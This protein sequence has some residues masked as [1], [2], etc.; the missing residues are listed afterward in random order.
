[1]LTS[2]S[3]RVTAPLRWISRARHQRWILLGARGFGKDGP[4]ETLCKVRRLVSTGQAA[5]ALARSGL[6]DRGWYASNNPDVAGTG[7]DPLWHFVRY[8]ASEKRRAS[9]LF[10]TRWYLETYPDVA[11]SG[12]NPLLH[13]LR[14]GAAEGRDPNPY[15]DSHWYLDTY[16]DVAAAGM[17]PLVH[18]Q[19]SGAAE[20]R[21]PSKGFDPDKYSRC[22]PGISGGKA[23]ALEH[24]LVTRA[25]VSEAA[26]RAP[27]SAPCLAYQ[28]LI[29]IIVPCLSVE[30]K[31]LR[32]A[33]ASVQA[34]TYPNWELCVC[35]DGSIAADTIDALLDLERTEAR[36]RTT[37][38]SANLGMSEA[39][40]KALAFAKGDFVA[41][42]QNDD[43]LVPFALETCVAE[44][45]RDDGI[46][47]I[48][49][50]EDKL[51][52]WDER[53]EPFFKPDW[54]PSL[55]REVMY[56]GHLLLV[57][58]SLMEKIG[59]FDSTY[60]G[61]QDFELMLRLSEH[62][63]SIHHVRD[64]L[65]HR[66]RISG[67]VADRSDAEPMLGEK[68]VA[69]VNAHLLRVGVAG[70]A[71][72]HPSLAHRVIVKPLDRKHRPRVS[73]V[74]L[75]K[76][77]PELISRCLDSIF[78]KTDYQDFEVVVVDNETTDGEALAAIARH[79]VIR[80]PFVGRFDFSRANNTGVAA[81]SG[82]VLVLLN[83]AIEVIHGDWLDQMLFLLDDPDVAAVGPM[84]LYPDGTV[85]HAGFALGIGG[86]ADHVQRGLP[87]EADGH[88]GSLA[89]TREVSAVSFACVM[90]RR[91]D[92]NAVGGLQD[93][94]GTS[95]Q[96][97]DFCLRLREQG[98][99]IL[100]TP[101]TCLIHRE[102]AARGP[103]YDEMDRALLLDAWGTTI[104]AGDPYSRWE[105][106]A[107]TDIRAA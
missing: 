107:P 16:S 20:G 58:R 61:V 77:A 33:V 39:T 106:A 103:A 92:Y 44:L 87:A 97:V 52:Y 69:A 98:R 2:S 95:Y 14:N 83:N 81:T 42:L 26:M 74:V 91:C 59:G 78:T 49:S 36:L 65:Y 7:V 13:Y 82:E 54:S 4:I 9:P 57:R 30:S 71:L 89:C 85:Q 45:N 50:D 51:G 56:V 46:D 101:R 63:R 5:R 90:M 100:Y 73:I 41:L 43:E 3:W 24:F 62:T 66:R 80:V 17:N 31:W 21:L 32:R 104:S 8:G 60:D 48:Y 86:T 68:Q 23:R 93:L 47:V 76:D 19:G 15:F 1:M 70:Y 102:S 75:T 37:P 53:E 40:N 55:L 27:G 25:A 29:S 105:R 38:L 6:F 11:A 72:P 28:P 35:A 67:S 79:C 10:D 64:I 88:F 22:H 34:Q 96:D 12:Q 18:Y 99:R 84:L 94:Y